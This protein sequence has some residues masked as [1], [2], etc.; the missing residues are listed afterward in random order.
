MKSLHIK[1]RPTSFSDVVGQQDVVDS[2]VSALDKKRSKAFLFH[3]PSGTG[4]TTLARIAAA[5]VGA[6]SNLSRME[7]DAASHNGI[8]DIRLI[9]GNL[10]YMPLGEKDTAK[11]VILDECHAL[12]AAAWKALLKPL[13]EPKS[14]VYWFLCTTEI[15][16]VPTNIRN[17]RCTT[18]QLKEVERK[19]MD[20]FLRRIIKLE[21]MDVEEDIITLC[22]K[23]AEGSPRHAISN[24]ETVAEAKS[25]KQARRM[26]QSAEGVTGAI[27]LARALH[28]G[29][30]FKEVQELL[31]MLK[32]Q[33]A[34]SVRHVVRSYMTN[35]ALGAESD[36]KAGRALE[37]LDHFL[38]PWQTGDQLSPLVM[39]CGRLCLGG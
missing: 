13:E 7:I 17:Q 4:K 12:S 3:G 6:K 5:H 35:V 9:T 18:Y 31:K 25:V 26:L 16:K 37:V 2:L 23:M 8:D 36:K 38:T 32:E 11:A 28:R 20:K 33:N 10:Q 34:E 29:A 1:Y 15:S 30:S 14:H 22:I 39:A 24:L 27:D 21:K 19:E